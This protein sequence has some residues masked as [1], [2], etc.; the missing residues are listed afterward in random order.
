[1]VKLK[2]YMGWGISWWFNGDLVVTNGDLVVTNGDLV[3]I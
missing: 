3:V 1:M 2:W